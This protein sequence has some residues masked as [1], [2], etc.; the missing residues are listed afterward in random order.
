[1]VPMSCTNE[2]PM[3]PPD[4]RIP[5]RRPALTV[6]FQSGACHMTNS[7]VFAVLAANQYASPMVEDETDVRYQHP[8]RPKP[9][10]CL[11]HER[12]G[13]NDLSAS[14]RNLHILARRIL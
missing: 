4:T 14:T 12:R 6:F 2:L 7:D 9:F 11:L 8:R 5:G 1:M 3:C 10:D 13:P